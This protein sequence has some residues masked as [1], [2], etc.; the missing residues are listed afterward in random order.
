MFLAQSDKSNASNNAFDA[1]TPPLRPS[2]QIPPE[3]DPRPQAASPGDP[4]PASRP[5][6][7]DYQPIHPCESVRIRDSTIC[8]I[9]E[10]CGL[11]PARWREGN[12][13]YPS[14][15]YAIAIRAGPRQ[16]SL[17]LLP[18]NPKSDKRTDQPR[19]PPR[20][21]PGFQL[22]IADPMRYNTTPME[23]DSPQ[24]SP[25]HPGIQYRASSIQIPTEPQVYCL[26]C[27]PGRSSRRANRHREPQKTQNKAKLRQPGQHRQ[28]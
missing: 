24:S 25:Q 2:S 3:A 21:T 6:T 28:E 18:P 7:S 22:T 13:L 27:I 9:C 11:N 4:E 26:A 20:S 15:W 16:S 8:V 17:A 19:S 23:R 12:G 14:R 1:T 5:T 10:I